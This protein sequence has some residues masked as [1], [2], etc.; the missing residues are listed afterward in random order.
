MKAYQLMS[1]STGLEYKDVPVPI[2]AK[3]Q[4]L[5]EVKATG[6]C[7][8]DHN[9]I[10][11]LDNTFFWKRPIILGHEIAGVVVEIGSDVTRFKVGD[12]VVAVIGT[13]HPV[14]FGDVVTAA[15][16]GYD[17]GFA[18]YVAV[19]EPKT[20]R[21]PE[22]VTFPQAAV[23]TDAIATA[24]HAVV[25]EAEVSAS[26][27][28]A[29]IGLGGL[30]LC[31]AQIACS[32]GAKVYGIE[33]DT[34]K[35]V[36]A[37][38]AGVYACAKSFDGFPGVRF[39]A[40]IDFAGTG[41]TT[42]TAARAV[43]PG[44]KVV[45]VG[46]SKKHVTLDTQELVALGVTLKGSAGSSIAEVEKSL[47]LIANKDIEPLLEEIPFSKIKEGLDRLEKGKVIGRLYADPTKA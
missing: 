4:L 30:G 8:T 39:D 44:G 5:V 41:T 10:S 36:A 18:Q 3:D 15:G 21:I 37:A 13:E 45:L 38:Q 2:P 46:L 16:I 25:V 42:A 26:S 11:G 1:P 23:A 14:T 9:I 28:I 20:V 6:I 17:G 47:Q 27:K 12:P 31:A 19:F 24:Y 43:K 7:H 33:L 34:P 22:G 35:F 29:I 40:V 32:L